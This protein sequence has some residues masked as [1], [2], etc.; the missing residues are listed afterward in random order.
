MRQTCRTGTTFGKYPAAFCVST[1]N[2]F[3]VEIQNEWWQRGKNDG[4]Q[5]EL[6]W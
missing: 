6:L 2:A 1:L 3:G 5:K 4:M